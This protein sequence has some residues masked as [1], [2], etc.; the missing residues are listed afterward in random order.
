MKDMLSSKE[1]IFLDKMSKGIEQERR[2]F[3]LILKKYKDK[4]EIR[5][6][7]YALAENGFFKSERNPTPEPVDDKGHFRIP[8]WDALDYLVAVAE[9]VSG[10]AD[11]RLAKDIMDIIRN[12][13]RARGTD[14][15]YCDNYYTA[16]RFAI[17]LGL[18]PTSVISEEDLDIIPIWLQGKFEIGLVSQA[19]SQG[20][21]VRMLSSENPDDWK[22]AF[23][24]LRYCTEVQWVDAP[25]FLGRTRQQPNTIVDDFALKAI[26]DQSA[27]CLGAKTGKDVSDLFVERLREVFD[28]VRRNVPSWVLRP[29]I[30]DHPQNHAWR[31]AENR[32]VEGLRDML[33]IWI[34]HDYVSAHAFVREMLGAGPEIGRRISIYVISRCWDR[35]KD[36]YP[37]ILAP[38][39]FDFEYAHETYDML[40]EHFSDFIEA[41]KERV[42]DV[43]RQL[44]AASGLD[45]AQRHLK[46]RQRD[47]LSAVI[48]QGYNPADQWFLELKGDISLGQVAE[49]PNFNAYSETLTG[50]GRSSFQ[51]DELIGFAQFGNIVER[52]NGFEQTGA[53]RAPTVQ[54]LVKVLEDAVTMRPDLFLPLLP[55]FL[56]ANRPYQYGIINGFKGLVNSSTDEERIDW[57]EAWEKLMAFFEAIIGA[58]DF[59]EGNGVDEQHPLFLLEPNKNWITTVIADFLKLGTQN[60]AHAYPK[61]L[62]PRGWV[63][64]TTFLEHVAPADTLAA[65]A[66]LQALNTRKGKVLDALYNHALRV[67]RVRDVETGNHEQAWAEMRPTF[68]VELGRCNGGNYEFSTFTGCFAASFE[69]LAPDWLGTHISQIFPPSLYNN[70]LRCA[71]GGL[72]YTQKTSWLYRQLAAHGVLKLALHTDLVDWDARQSILDMM[73]LAYLRGDEDLGSPRFAYLFGSAHVKYIEEVGR[74]FW[75]V[76]DQGLSASQISRILEFWEICIKWARSNSDIQSELLPVLGSLVCYLESL[77]EREETLLTAVAPFM[78]FGGAKDFL[79]YNFIA[80]LDRL[81]DMNPRSVADIVQL[82]VEKNQPKF[83]LQDH[84]KSIIEKIAIAGLIDQA[85]YLTEKLRSLSGMDSLWKKLDSIVARPPSLDQ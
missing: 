56:E 1:Q 36:L 14:G 15:S 54:G 66:M 26:I 13:S 55:A 34:N 80:D 18:L 64:I 31:V 3:Q 47:W 21:F 2:G 75:S 39:F 77:G 42:V 6:F 59:W 50:P 30:E 22:K 76:R 70:N 4:G 82:L 73:A 28:P 20:L 71:L 16:H 61:S 44:P 11:A 65:D 52:L 40:K 38:E 81:A 46:A 12:V 32:F 24:I 51:T 45:D 60:D 43:I 68:D 37:A 5:K 33:L 83:D 84:L 35:L 78:S 23:R 53:W 8:Y 58:P 48:E 63:L 19:L 67:C 17:V 72:V 85:R 29:A 41:D 27:S 9:D 25:G 10:Q 69:Y 7:F 79:T 57:S 74:F 62:L 49:H